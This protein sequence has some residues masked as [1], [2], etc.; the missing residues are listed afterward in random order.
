[1]NFPDEFIFNEITS[2]LSNKHVKLNPEAIDGLKDLMKLGFSNK[3]QFYP[4]SNDGQKVKAIEDK[5]ANMLMNDLKYKT[6]LKNAIKDKAFNNKPLP[7]KLKNRF[8]LK[9]KKKLLELNKFPSLRKRAKTEG[10]E[11]PLINNKNKGKTKGIELY[12]K[13]GNKFSGT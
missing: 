13:N 9:P 8:R 3:A 10:K 7:G 11:N 12:D 2:I 4:D 6:G 1:M 5:I